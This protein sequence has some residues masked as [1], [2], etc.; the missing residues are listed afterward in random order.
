MDPLA[1]SPI[2]HP[3]IAMALSA[4]ILAVVVTAV[5]RGRPWLR[6]VTVLAA[7]LFAALLLWRTHAD[8]TAWAVAADT[9]NAKSRCARAKT[10]MEDIRSNARQAK[11]DVVSRQL[12]LVCQH[13]CPI[14]HPGTNADS[15]CDRI[16]T[17][18]TNMDQEA[19]AMDSR[20]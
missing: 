12:D 3:K 18:S 4:S 5:L 19:E 8:L 13:A 14:F 6:V 16:M 20:F 9:I 15:L 10:L 11:W 7:A 17:L 2:A 1:L